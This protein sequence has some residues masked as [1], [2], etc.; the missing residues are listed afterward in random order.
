MGYAG[1]LRVRLDGLYGHKPDPDN[2]TPN[3]THIY[4]RVRQAAGGKA[5]MKS[6]V[7]LP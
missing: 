5:Y 3:L 1:H 6:L 2:T 4:Q 7:T